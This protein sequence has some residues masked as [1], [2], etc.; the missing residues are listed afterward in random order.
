VKNY[1]CVTCGTQYE[2]A[3]VP[4]LVCPVCVDDRQFVGLDGQQWTTH[5]T[6]VGTLHNRIEIDDGL[7]GI[8]I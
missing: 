1:L 3:K 7:L 6:L 5:E 8:G 4:P 2:A